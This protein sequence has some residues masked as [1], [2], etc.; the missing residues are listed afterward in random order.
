[1]T[2]CWQ[3]TA[4][5]SLFV[6][7]LSLLLLPLFWVKGEA[8]QSVQVRVNRAIVVQRVDGQVMFQHQGNSRP[9]RVGDRLQVAGDSII[10]G[11]SS[12]AVLEVDTGIGFINVSENT[13]VKTR[14]L[15]VAPDNGRITELEVPHGQVRLRLRR[16]THR[17]SRLRIQTPA[18]VSAVRGTEFGVNVQADGR[19]GVATQTG[20]VSTSAQGQ[21]VDVPAQ[22]Q[23][24]TFPGE[25]PLP[26]VPLRDDP[27]LSYT[28][29]REIRGGVRRIRF[30]GQVDSVNTV[31]Y[32]NNQ[33]ILDREGRFS[34]TLPAYSSQRLEITVITPL[35]RE[36]VH[37][38]RIVL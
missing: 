2:C 34:I 10:T 30:I 23:N 37:R 9:A 19:M 13:H 3:K 36:Q 26:A 25:A 17:G 20:A 32:R 35:G 28:L 4:P 8:Q 15:S 11:A 16:F 27:G 6:M 29:E 33:Q 5:H 24:L 21:T 31:L 7:L 18:G 22:F 14:L 38:V 12:G 1:M